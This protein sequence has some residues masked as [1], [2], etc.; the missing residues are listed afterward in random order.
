MDQDVIGHLIDVERAAFDMMMDAQTEADNRK[1]AVK[2]EAEQ[3]YLKAYSSIVQ[4][5]EAALA[6]EKTRCDSAREQEYAE[7]A[8][9]LG[10]INQDR[11]A[12]NAYLNS[13][14]NGI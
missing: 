3:R 12:F 11:N 9:R 10:A 2:D 5:K 8:D 14:F 1:T 7:I 6:V 13:L 4:E